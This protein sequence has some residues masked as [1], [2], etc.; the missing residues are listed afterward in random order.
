[1]KTHRV[2]LTLLA[3]CATALFVT[4]SPA[5]ADATITIIN[6]DGPNEGFNDPTPAAPVGG[7][8]G[9]TLGQQRLIVFQYAADIW[10]S[11]LDSDEQIDIVA[12]FD[13]LGPNVLG[14]AGTV[15]VARD[16]PGAVFPDTWYHVALANKLVGVDLSPG[17]PDI[18]A[19]FSSDTAFYLGLDNNH[20]VLIDLPAVVLHEFGHGL[21]FANFVSDS[22]AN[23]AGHTDVYSQ[24]TFDETLGL[25]WSGMT[26]PQRQ[27]STT[28]VRHVV[29]D[30]PIVT[31]QIPRVLQIGEPRVFV[32]SPSSID[33]SYFVGPASFGPAFSSPGVT[34]NVTL[35][36]DGVGVT[37]D[38]C[39]ALPAASLTGTVGLADRGT[40]TFVVKV[41]N[42]QNAGAIGALIADN[43]AGTP[44]STMGGADLTITIPSGRITLADGNTIKSQLAGGVNTNLGLDLT[45]RAGVSPP[46]GSVLLWAA[47]PVQ[48]GSSISHWDIITTPNQLM[49]PS[50]NA[51]LTHSVRPPQDLTLMQLGDIGWFTDADL[52]GVGD[53]DD[54]CPGSNL[55]A[56]VIIGTCNS[57]VPNTVLETG[58]SISDLIAQCPAGGGFTSCVSQVTND[59]KADGVITGAQKDAIMTCAQ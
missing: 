11:V 33:G 26:K 12:S 46:S 14:Q 27:F 17:G 9:T 1:M 51:S 58:C 39:Q 57:G 28:N 31:S 50:I 29:W 53:D 13:P 21:G 49:E 3:V 19:Q 22:G 5:L 18:A 56:T 47:N 55:A 10:G 54:Q 32:N 7:N 30:G 41:K 59:L 40:C 2:F 6:V 36:N 16:F 38:A 23:F 8:P 43:V 44:P 34:G 52:D 15:S 37:T 20:G 4:T 25:N 42:M 35:A 24:F 45:R 48:P